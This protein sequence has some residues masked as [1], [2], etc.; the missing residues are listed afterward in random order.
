INGSLIMI[1]NDTT[2]NVRPPVLAPAILADNS[3]ID[4]FFDFVGKG[5]KVTMNNI[6]LLSVRADQ[7]QLSWS[8]GFRV[9]ADSVK[10]RLRGVIF[11]AFSDA[12]IT[13]S[14]Q[15]CKFDIQ[16]CVFRNHQHSSAWFG[17]QPLMTGS[18]VHLDT[19]K[20]V[21]NTFIAN[22]SY[23]WSVRGY[24]VFSLFEH[25]T[26]IF[27]A[28]NPFLTRQGDHL[29]IRNN[30]F[31]MM[32]AMGGNPDHVINSWFLN[33]PDTGSSPIIQLRGLDT[34]S[35]WYHL[36]GNSAISGPNAYIDSAHGVTAGMVDPSKRIFD[37]RNND[38]FWPAN[39]LNFVKSWNDTVQTK[40]SVD[41]PNGTASE[42]KM[43][44]KRIL[45]YPTWLSSYAKWT[46]DSLA[47]KYSPNI[48]NL[49]NQSADPG[50]PATVT[51]HSAN[52]IN[53]VWKISAGT[54][55]TTW[56]YH[57]TAA[58]YPPVWPLPE[59]L[60]YTNAAL[61]N[62][63]TDGFAL[64]DLNWFPTQK[65]SWLLTGVTNNGGAVPETYA[66]SQNYP[67]PFNPS[68]KIDFSIPKTSL[69]ELK[70]YN[71]LGQEV[72]TLVNA[73]LTPGSHTATFDARNLA[74][75]V[76]FYHITAG[77]FNSVKKMM[78]LK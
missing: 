21:N 51:N 48:W 44:L 56:F 11:D 42:V 55:D 10:I 18:P 17:G 65:A 2:G 46:I 40:D 53:Y 61:Q 30:I 31:Y 67:N 62:A 4:H 5:G 70:I 57:P 47:R 32:N 75:G 76:Y 23:S 1:A 60:A 34:V 15:W 69:V 37:L 29:R 45:Y 72:A 36:W 39:Y 20:V 41:V 73:V 14:G 38:Y 66:L 52:L 63:G 27:G 58:M 33:Y 7:A 68:T 24:D 35:A 22:N 3:S 50:F 54:L 71:V 25:N 49:N 26:M 43:Y 8:D 16:D 6:Y 19:M 28:V 9:G 77:E 78:L 13:T 74:S 59:N 12:G 64:G